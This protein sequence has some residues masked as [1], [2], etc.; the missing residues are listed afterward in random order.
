MNFGWL[1]KG[2][3]SPRTAVQ[4]SG[5]RTEF[6][7]CWAYSGPSSTPFEAATRRQYPCSIVSR[8]RCQL[9][10]VDIKA[11]GARYADAWDTDKSHLDVTIPLDGPQEW[12]FMDLQAGELRDCVYP[13]DAEAFAELLQLVAR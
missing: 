7:L 2:M 6:G 10:R 11:G 3:V 9:F 13:N 12:F 8:N 1:V 5:A 4:P